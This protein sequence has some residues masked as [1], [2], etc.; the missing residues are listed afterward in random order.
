MVD[1]N[2]LNYF[3]L[4]YKKWNNWKKETKEFINL[5]NCELDKELGLEK[6][7]V[8][9]PEYYRYDFSNIRMTKIVARGS[10]FNSCNF[11]N[12]RLNFSDLCYSVFVD[13]NFEGAN[14]SVSKLGSTKFIN[15]SFKGAKLSYCSCED[16]EFES[17]EFS[18]TNMDNMSLVK[19]SFKNSNLSNVTMYGTS[20]WDLNLEGTS[21]EE[22]HISK[23]RSS[24]S[25]PNI[26]LAQFIFLLLNNSKIR[27]VI[28]SV[29]SKV[30]LILGN[31]ENKLILNKIKEQIK[32]AGYLPVIY[33]F[34]SPQNRNLT[35]TLKILAGLSKFII[36]DLSNPRSV[37]HELANVVVDFPSVPIQP[38]INSSEKPYVMIEMYKNLPQFLDLLKYNND[39]LE[40]IINKGILLCEKCFKKN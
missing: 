30:V 1:K 28:E 13:C 25:V 3:K 26:E 31:F 7:I 27:S 36:V 11:K 38:L 16:S 8:S 23:D 20:V 32:I 17:S 21:Q 15:C 37:P 39:D 29:T 18:G 4:G 19:T 6:N 14:L 2:S 35:E 12:T 5:G 33:D 22:I 40:G 34:C 24:I 10:I 9:I